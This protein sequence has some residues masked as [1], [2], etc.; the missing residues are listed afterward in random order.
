MRLKKSKFIIIIVIFCAGILLIV[1]TARL[2][3]SISTPP[4]VINKTQETAHSERLRP[5]KPGDGEDEDKSVNFW[6]DYIQQLQRLDSEKFV[7]W[8]K[9]WQNEQIG[10]TVRWHA[11]YR[12]SLTITDKPGEPTGFTSLI[13]RPYEERLRSV[14]RIKCSVPSDDELLESLSVDKHVVLKGKIKSIIRN[15]E[16]SGV[17]TLPF[18]S[19]LTVSLTE[20][21]VKELNK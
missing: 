19:A 14:I 8:F 20:V 16:L 2:L 17:E 11:V 15:S 1:R 12:G 10:K 9:Q 13:F 18:G 7:L 6:N 3:R 5:V 4:R 21:Q